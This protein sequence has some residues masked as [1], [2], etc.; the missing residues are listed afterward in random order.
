MTDIQ[1]Q[2]RAAGYR[3]IIIEK[4]FINDAIGKPKKNDGFEY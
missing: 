2:S 1:L 3:I 4:R